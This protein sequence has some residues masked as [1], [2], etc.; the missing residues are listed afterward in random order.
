M[1]D[2][3]A[4]LIREQCFE[5]LEQE[6]PF[7]VGVLVE[8]FKEE[9]NIIKIEAN[10]IVEKDNHKG[11]VIGRGGQ[12]LKKIGESSR[13]KIE[14]ML[15]QKIYLGLHVSHKP[16]WTDQKRMMKELGYVTES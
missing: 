6:I 12:N 8:S 10:I 7:G 3:A 15:G 14:Q 11:I 13:K 16:N 2:I 5:L 9:A 4:E 1:R